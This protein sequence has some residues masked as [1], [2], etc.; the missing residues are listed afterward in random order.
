MRLFWQKSI[1]IS[2]NIVSHVKRDLLK[3]LCSS[4]FFTKV[5][6][7]APLLKKRLLH[8]CFPVNFTKFLR[9]PLL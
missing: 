8:R 4:L 7:C 1:K 9:T 3:N 5:A 6:E 2:L